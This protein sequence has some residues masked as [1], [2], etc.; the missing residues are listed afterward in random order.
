MLRFKI[1]NKKAYN[2]LYD[3]YKRH[4][5][6]KAIFVITDLEYIMCKGLPNVTYGAYDS[7]DLNF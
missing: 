5:N 6:K 3:Y 1:T 4:P 7:G 2:K